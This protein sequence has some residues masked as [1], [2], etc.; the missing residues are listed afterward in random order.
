MT[1]KIEAY[2]VFAGGGVKGAALAGAL[3]AAQKPVSFVG[4]GDT[5]AGSIIAFLASIGYSTEDIR[6]QRIK[7]LSSLLDD[8]PSFAT[9]ETKISEI[10]GI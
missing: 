8:T 4:F 6:K 3:S 5:S 9:L 1:E 10:R 7:P 2:A